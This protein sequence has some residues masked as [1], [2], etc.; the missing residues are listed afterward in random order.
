MHRPTRILA[1]ATVLALGLTS[2]ASAGYDRDTVIVKFKD[3]ATA[4]AQRGAVLQRAG[5]GP[6]LGTVRG[7][8]A[9]VVRTTADPAVVAGRLNRSAL[10][11]Y[12]EVNQ[13]LRASAVPND[14]R[15]GELYG[16]N[17]TGQTGGTPDAD[18]DAPE[19]WDA[20]GLGTFP[21]TGG[22]KVGIVD[23][24]IRASHQD[25]A[26]KV[27]D[28]AQSR[29]FLIF[30]GSIRAGCADDNGH[31]TH[32]AGTIGANTNNGVGVAGVAFNSPLGIC[33]AL[34]GPAGTG[35][36]ADV[37]NCIGYLHDTGSKVIS[38]SLGG[39]DSTTLRNAVVR[40]Y[41]NG[42]SN[43]SLIVA[44]AG[45][46][47]NA[48]VNYPAGYAEVVSVAATD[49]RDQ[50]ASFSNANADVEVAA[51]GVNILST[52]FSSDSSYNTIS[53]TS[54][55]TPHVA[56]VA[57]IIAGRNAG[58]TVTTIRSRLQAATDDLGAPG[59]DASFGFG[60]VN[61]SKAG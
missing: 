20:T 31:G 5:A 57:A 36:T 18:I 17:N 45:N 22:A 24:G 56:G 14:A 58:A 16:L 1:L 26:G 54:M 12:A 60:R 46:D 29:G 3:S 27:A 47:G 10:V 43:G 53:G 49:N 4:A 35:N 7:L 38:M 8:G 32:V 33:R 61:L 23:T 21:A 48:T 50:R 6:V 44:A 30:A 25:L 59:R 39:G 40:A 9:N 11:Q 52:W 34:G 28:C 37:A 2:A 15:F 41:R 51:P 19:G 55:A 13:I 42:A